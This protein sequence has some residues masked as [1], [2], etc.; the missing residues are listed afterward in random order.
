MTIGRH[1]LKSLPKIAKAIMDNGAYFNCCPIL[2]A[3]Q[4]RTSG[5]LP[6]IFRPQN[7]PGIALRKEDRDVANRIVKELKSL[8]KL[9]PA[10]SAQ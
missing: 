1:N 9:R 8:K 7:F 3:R 2:Y 10:F 4:E 6:F 5:R